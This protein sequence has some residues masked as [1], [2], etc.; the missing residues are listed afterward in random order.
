MCVECAEGRFH[1]N[2]DQFLVEVENGEL[3][4]TTLAREAMPLLR[5]TTRVSCEI[6]RDK[7]PCG[8][9]GAVLL[10]GRRLDQQLCIREMPVY[11]SQM[12]E[13]LSH[14]RAAGQRVR[15]GHTDRAVLVAIEVTEA[16]FDDRM[17]TLE[18]VGLEVQSEFL[19][20]LGLEAKV[21]F[22]SPGGGSAA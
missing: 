15:L 12:R 16:V 1:V 17:R 9:T 18:T 4:V 19:A 5:Y 10:P 21:T 8:R 6:H 3:L 13:V 20:R 2:E 7:C 11:E 22:V 14:T